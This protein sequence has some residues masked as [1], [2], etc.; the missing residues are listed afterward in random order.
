V[1]VSGDGARAAHYWTGHS[2]TN[3]AFKLTGV[4]IWEFRDERLARVVEYFDT[5]PIAR[6]IGLVPQPGT[7]GA[8]TMKPNAPFIVQPGEEKYVDI[9]GL[10]VVFKVWGEATGHNL[11]VV[12]HPGAECC[13]W[14]RQAGFRETH[15]TPLDGSFAMVVGIK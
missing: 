6:Q 13:A 5:A 9:G 2:L 4:S 8:Q 11:S 3:Q 7:V 1:F 10:G 14:L 15:V 12:E